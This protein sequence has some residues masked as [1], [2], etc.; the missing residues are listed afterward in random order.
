MFPHSIAQRIV[1]KLTELLSLRD[2]LE[3]KL[4]QPS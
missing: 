2:A 1:S 4:T 3:A